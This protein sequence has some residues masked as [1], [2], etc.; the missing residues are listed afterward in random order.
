MIVTLELSAS[1]LFLGGFY[2]FVRVYSGQS[3]GVRGD[4]RQVELIQQV[5]MTV[6]V[7]NGPLSIIS[8]SVP[9]PNVPW[10]ILWKILNV[11]SGCAPASRRSW[12]N[13]VATLA[14]CHC[15]YKEIVNKLSQI[16]SI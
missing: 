7:F 11:L 5:H 12:I 3:K 16:K 6:W 4:H 10:I 1:L 14:A 13:I 8:S 9:P 15:S 2:K